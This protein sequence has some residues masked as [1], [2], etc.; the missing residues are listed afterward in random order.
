MG[1]LSLLQL[2]IAAYLKKKHSNDLNMII[3]TKFKQGGN[4][5]ERTSRTSLK[6]SF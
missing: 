6:K 3:K 4:R 2:Q 5:K 1:M